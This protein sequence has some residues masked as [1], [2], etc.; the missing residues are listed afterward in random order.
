MKGLWKVLWQICR[1]SSG[2]LDYEEAHA[3]ELGLF[4]PFILWP[5]FFRYLR[6]VAV[7][8]CE[9]EANRFIRQEAHYLA[10]GMALRALFI[11]AILI[12]RGIL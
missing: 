1:T 12:W 5:F 4:F 11:M 6:Y 7:A 8:E 10:F 2:G 9:G 3:I